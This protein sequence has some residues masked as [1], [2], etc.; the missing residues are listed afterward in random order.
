MTTL[1]FDVPIELTKLSDILVRL[2][3][4]VLEADLW[5]S[6]KESQWITKITI[7][8]AIPVEKK[9]D[10][11]KLAKDIGAALEM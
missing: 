10:M 9:G 1:C 8:P 2:N 4:I 11:E 5:I 6:L 7:F 3:E